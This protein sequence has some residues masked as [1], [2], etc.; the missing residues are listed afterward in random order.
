MDLLESSTYNVLNESSSSFFNAMDDDFNT[1][2]AI[3]SLFELIN[4]S[5]NQLNE[6]NLDDILAIKKFFIIVNDILGIF[7]LDD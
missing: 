6:L 4:N 2:K 3:S 7:F 1:P 5:K